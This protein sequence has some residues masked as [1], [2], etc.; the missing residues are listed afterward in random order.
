[1]A[2]I[3][4]QSASPGDADIELPNDNGREAAAG[5]R[6][7]ALSTEDLAAVEAITAALGT[8]DGRVDGIETL[9][10][11]TNT[12]LTTI[13]GRVD[14]LEALITTLN[15]KIDT[16]DTSVDAVATAVAAA[17]AATTLAASTNN[18][19]DVDVLSLPALP[20]G[21]NNIGDV[22]VASLPAL[23]AGNNN[24]GDVDVASLPAIP[25]GTNMIGHVGGTD[26]ETVAASQTDQMCGPTGAAGDYL[27]HLLVIPA[28]TSP[29]AVSIEDGATNTTVFTGGASSVSNLVPFVI[30]IGAK[31]TS[32]GWEVTTGANVSVIAFGDFT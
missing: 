10:G 27:S 17:A 16:L 20:A 23:P 1:M 12:T 15:G 19:G 4:G 26:Y 18:I 25:A 22:D 6:P 30:P 24:I 11:T 5:S 2:T 21:T 31:S 13:D 29:G 32:G 8:I 14:G 9:I 3:R 28:T 7:V